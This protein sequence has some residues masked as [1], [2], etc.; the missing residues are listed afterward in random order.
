MRLPKVSSTRWDFTS[1]L[2][3]TVYKWREELLEL[4]EFIVTNRIYYDKNAV[5][6]VDGYLALRTSFEFSFLLSIFMSVFAYPAVLFGILQNTL[7]NMQFW[8]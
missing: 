7:Y 3:C 5:H 2:V 6:R 4:I 1:C 8:Y